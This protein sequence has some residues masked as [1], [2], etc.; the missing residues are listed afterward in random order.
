MS[1]FQITPLERESSELYYL[2][3]I[4]AEHRS[5]SEREANHP[6]YKLLI[7]RACPISAPSDSQATEFPLQQ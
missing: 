7:S 2:S 6:Q 4:V 1:R 3:K 5:E